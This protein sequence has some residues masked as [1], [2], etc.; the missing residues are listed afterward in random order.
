MSTTSLPPDAV[1]APSNEPAVKPPVLASDIL[2]E[3][4]APLAPARRLIRIWLGTFAL[5]CA[6]SATAARFGFGPHTAN[7]FEGSLVAA[8]LASIG[9]AVPASYTARATMAIVSGLSL[10]VLGALERGPLAPLGHLGVF[11]AAM[12]ILLVL[13][14]PPALLFRSRYRAFPEARLVLSIALLL[15]IPALILAVLGALD[16]DATL[17]SRIA[18]GVLVAAILTGL[19]GYM[20]AETTG[21]CARWAGF[22]LVAYAGRIAV[23][24]MPFHNDFSDSQPLDVYGHWGYLVASAGTLAATTLLAVGLYQALATMFAKQAREV[25]VHRTAARS[26]PPA[27]REDG[28]TA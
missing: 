5:A 8:I 11:R 22:L 15:S 1:P 9:A 7:V 4:V 24:V 6:F 3:E 17:P 12:G 25:D 16:G 27:D 13:T 10:L 28:G 26:L 19:F 2:R 23:Q 18:D 14:L 20:G 21:G